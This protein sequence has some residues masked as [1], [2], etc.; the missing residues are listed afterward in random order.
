MKWC[1]HS[2]ALLSAPLHTPWYAP[3]ANAFKNY[4]NHGPFTRTFKSCV[5]VCALLEIHYTVPSNFKESILERSALFLTLSTVD[6]QT[7]HKVN[8]ISF[9][10][11]IH[12]NYLKIFMCVYVYMSVFPCVWECNI[13]VCEGQNR[14]L[15]PLDLKLQACFG[16]LAWYVG[17]GMHPVVLT[18]AQQ[19]LAAALSL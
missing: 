14:A 17:V 10:L 3:W 6:C 15:N 9:Y 4:V 1:T 12:K 19:A 18:I 5:N 16:C 7:V 2:P 11:K 8:T 13:C